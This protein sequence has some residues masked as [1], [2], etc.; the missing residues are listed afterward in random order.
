MLLARV[1]HTK[2]GVDAILGLD[3]VLLTHVLEGTLHVAAEEVSVRLVLSACW[4]LSHK[5]SQ[6]LNTTG[7]WTIIKT[8]WKSTIHCIVTFGQSLFYERSIQYMSI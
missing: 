1:K 2:H 6:E 4:R 7:S 8:Y 3:K 5:V